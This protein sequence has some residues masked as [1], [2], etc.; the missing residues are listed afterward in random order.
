MRLVHNDHGVGE[1]PQ[2]NDDSSDDDL[3]P[4]TK[5]PDPRGRRGD[6][7]DDDYKPDPFLDGPRGEA[8]LAKAR[9]R[10]PMDEGAIGCFRPPPQRN[11][12]VTSTSGAGIEDLQEPNCEVVT[13][14]VRDMS[15]SSGGDVREVVTLEVANMP[16]SG[17]YNSDLLCPTCQTLFET[18]R[19]MDYH[20]PCSGGTETRWRLA[21]RSHLLS[22]LPETLGGHHPSPQLRKDGV[23]TQDL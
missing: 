15:D 19:D 3:V 7:S 5:G 2:S 6:S 4:W 12:E 13:L 18:E 22:V 9:S 11:D 20:E 16:D 14:K 17:G 8:I 10:A 23:S 1:Y 21:V